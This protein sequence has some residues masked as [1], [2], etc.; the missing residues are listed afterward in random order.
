MVTD[1]INGVPT[2][3]PELTA[4]GTGTGELTVQVPLTLDV[5]QV[6]YTV[7]AAGGGVPANGILYIIRVTQ[8]LKTLMVDGTEPTQ[9]T[10]GYSY[11][12]PNDAE[13]V[14]VTATANSQF[15]KVSVNGSTPTFHTA[16]VEV[17]VLQPNC[18][19]PLKIYTYPYR[20]EDAINTSLVI[21]RMGPAYN[22][23]YLGSRELGDTSANTTQ[24]PKDSH[25]RYVLTM[26][27]TISGMELH[28]YTADPADELVLVKQGATGSVQVQPE[29]GYPQSSA[30]QKWYLWNLNV[31]TADRDNYKL[32]VIHAGKA[33]EYDLITAKENNITGLSKIVVNEGL[34]TRNELTINPGWDD[35][36]VTVPQDMT[37]AHVT[38]TA[39]D[40][41]ATLTS[42]T[43]TGQGGLDLNVALNGAGANVS[44]T[45]TALDGTVRNYTLALVQ[46]LSATELGSVY[47]GDRE[48]TAVN[49]IYNATMDVTNGSAQLIIRAR[50]GATV[51]VYDENGVNEIATGGATLWNNQIPVTAGK[52]NR[53]VIEVTAA[54]GSTTKKYGLTLRADNF[55]VGV[56]SFEVRKDS[57]NTALSALPYV[58]VTP[59]DTDDRVYEVVLDPADRYVDFKVTAKDY[60]NKVEEG[61]GRAH[62]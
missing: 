31:P 51:R 16:T 14:T 33:M 6:N 2:Q 8:P 62:V 60:S 56:E 42:G 15:A 38:I 41:L 46:A 21:T 61:I 18:V 40:P 17:T 36:T 12:A 37:T 29:L 44:F 27:A 28:A 59:K 7:T 22:L 49:G 32:V 19:V 23:N 9:T 53:Y 25:G 11:V 30:T 43:A 52:V 48:L 35:Y 58:A 45:V 20:E 10:T 26:P 39:A 13:K 3:V 5:N 34:S 24:V 54:N 55:A 50:D 57:T 1:I 4:L 47:L